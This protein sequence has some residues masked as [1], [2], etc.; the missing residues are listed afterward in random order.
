M[1]QFITQYEA[2]FTA[3]VE[4][5]RAELQTIRG[6][7]AHPTLVE[8]LKVKAY[9]SEMRLQEVA[10]ITI[11]EPRMIVVQPW[12][13]T[14]LKDVERGLQ[15]ASLNLGI[16]N[17]GTVLRLTLPALTAESR[18]ALLKVLHQKLEAGRVQIR[19]LREK[20]REQIIK[21]ERDKEISEDDRF[22]A[23]EDLEEFVKGY[24][25]QVNTVGQRKE[26][27]ILTV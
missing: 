2:A 12:D 8:D 7:R 23:Q 26:E 14:L 19:Q 20:V 9:G 1:S 10:S 4:H 24:I 3:A 11:P 6:N 18:Q 15:E 5:V 16:T 17:D 13:K 21:A 27:E 25:E 22:K